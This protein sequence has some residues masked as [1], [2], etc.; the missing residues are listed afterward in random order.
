MIAIWQY[1]GQT[2]YDRGA[3]HPEPGDTLEVMYTDHICN[4]DVKHRINGTALIYKG[5]CI[6]QLMILDNTP[7]GVY[8]HEQNP[9][10][11]CHVKDNQ[12]SV[13]NV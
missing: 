4:A 1:R 3:I 8:Y 5:V 10:L 9:L 2:Y 11:V 6:E 7:L 12:W 13:C